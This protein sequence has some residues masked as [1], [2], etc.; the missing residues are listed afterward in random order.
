M[1]RSFLNIKSV[2]IAVAIFLVAGI[3]VWQGISSNGV[4]EPNNHNMS[5]V[6]SIVNAGILVFR[7]GLEAILV[8]SAMTAGLIRT[9]NF[10]WKPI[11]TGSGIGF[12]A[13][14]ISWFIIVA[15]IS[16]IKAP[17]YDIQAGT[18]LLAIVVLLI[19]MNWFF[20]KI[21][22]TGWIG[23]HNKKK[24]ELMKNDNSSSATYIGLALLGFSAI[25][26]EGFEV[27]LFLQDLRLKA[28][29]EVVLEGTVIGLFL[30]AIVAVLTFIA[31]KKLPYK[32]M[33]VFTGV[34][35]GIVLIVMVGESAQ[36]LQQAGWIPTTKINIPI[37]GWMGM[38][39]AVFPTVEGLAAQALAAIL[40]LGSYV[41]AEYVRRWK[42][43]KEIAAK[44][45]K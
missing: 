10:Y 45:A 28:G 33:L 16:S 1:A 17:E 44:N 9:K 43:H 27:D 21:Y 12:L 39:F 14:I 42:P 7:E 15:I 4:P 3:F 31:Q 11:F 40:V 34:L 29:S 20:H 25:Y 8:L 6:S 36:E 22:W 32:K 5:S 19:V 37:P 18:G 35:L 41:G 23:H 26:R 2:L 13:T 30:T 38:W 24:K